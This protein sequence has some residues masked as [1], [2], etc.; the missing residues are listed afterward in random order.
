MPTNKQKVYNVIS[1]YLPDC[2]FSCRDLHDLMDTHYPG[3][4]HN[5]IIP[6]DYLYEDAVKDDPSN[7]GN[8]DYD[9]TYPRFLKRIAKNTYR[10]GGWDGIPSGAI[11]APV[12]RATAA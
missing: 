7:N 3:T 9:E 5:S 10:F 4:P 6:S 12:L 8:R 11:D 1:A 2:A